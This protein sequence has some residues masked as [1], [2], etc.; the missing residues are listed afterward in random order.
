MAF[1][2]PPQI[3]TLE[4]QELSK[5]SSKPQGSGVGCNP[6]GTPVAIAFAQTLERNS[7]LLA[8]GFVKECITSLFSSSAEIKLIHF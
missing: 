2:F 1:F 8:R 6:A 7:C 4:F 3:R 5:Q